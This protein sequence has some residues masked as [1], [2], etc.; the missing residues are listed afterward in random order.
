MKCF[1]HSPQCNC[2]E[3]EFT[4]GNGNINEIIDTR[5]IF[6]ECGFKV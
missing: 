4:Q 2:K 5:A 6:I 3:K 1:Y